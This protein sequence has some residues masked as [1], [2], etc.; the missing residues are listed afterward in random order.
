VTTRWKC[1]CA[2]DGT[3]F[4]GWQSQAGGGT[5]QD[6][7]ESGL[8]RIFRQKIRIHGSSRTDSGVHARG[9]VFHFDADWRNPA[10]RLEA[11]LRT[12]IPATIQVSRIRAAPPEFHARLSA[13]GKRYR[14]FIHEGFADPFSVSYCWSVPR[15]ISVETMS[16]AAAI[17]QGRHDFTSFSAYAGREMETPVRNLR[18][19]EV[20][21]K[22]S[23]IVITAEADGFLY[24]MVRSLAGGLLNVGIGKLTP[25]QIREILESRART[26]LIETAPPHGL[27]LEKVFYP[28][29]T[30]ERQSLNPPRCL[31]RP[32]QEM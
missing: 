30:P 2:Y 4:K 26:A 13:S 23:R 10:V 12:V 5:V 22:G 32:A 9:M 28:P 21:R 29:G 8:E 11:A 6:V 7:I 18:K 19:L 14:Y 20:R 16:E 31:R 3:F 24:K 25:A 1:L 17:L 27:F 15:E